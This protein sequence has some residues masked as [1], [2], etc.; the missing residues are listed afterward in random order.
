MSWIEFNN[1]NSDEI[2]GDK[3]VITKRV[4]GTPT[5]KSYTVEV[6]FSSNMIDYSFINGPIFNNRPIELSINIEGYDR[7][8]MYKLYQRVI[9]WLLTPKYS[10]LKLSDVD[11]YFMAKLGSISKLEE[12]SYT[13]NIDINFTCNPWL[14]YEDIEIRN[15]FNKNDFLFLEGSFMPSTPTLITS[16]VCNI[17]F[18]GKIYTLLKGENKNF[19]IVFKDGLNELKLVT[20]GPIELTINYKRGG[21]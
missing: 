18:E 21:L 8:D 12:V 10:K 7:S 5:P 20:D 17:E 2:F 3:L 16:N 13:G 6:P 1:I 14:Y 15:I 4:I 19:D 9:Q 11:G